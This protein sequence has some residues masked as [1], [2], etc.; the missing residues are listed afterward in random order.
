MNAHKDGGGGG[1]AT[2]RMEEWSALAPL[3]AQERDSISK[4]AS[5][6]SQASTASLSN[7][8]HLKDSKQPVPDA[9]ND[10]TGD[11]KAESRIEDLLPS[12]GTG[13]GG[14]PS[15]ATHAAKAI[16]ALTEL[17]RILDKDILDQHLLRANIN[18]SELRAG[19]RLVEETAE[20]LRA[21]QQDSA[22]STRP[23]ASLANTAQARTPTQTAR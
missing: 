8:D 13:S 22:L 15:S 12:H 6:L 3:T 5:A 2:M 14:P 1:A 16:E 23:G 10:R 17:H 20:G 9:E 21:R 19:V 4:L 11:D 18:L 7:F